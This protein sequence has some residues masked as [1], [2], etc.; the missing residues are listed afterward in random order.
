MTNIIISIIVVL[1]VAALFGWLAKRAWGSRKA[2]VKWAG[3]ILGG[4]LALV[5]LVVAVFAGLGI[6]KLFMK[7]PIA[8]PDVT[9]QGT[10]DQIA[11]GQHL[12]QVLCAGCHSLT[13]DLPL[14]GGKN[15]SADTGMPLG[16]IYAPNLTPAT[17]IKNWS[18]SDLFRVIRTGIDDQGRAT[19][20]TF[21]V[22]V[23]TLSDE[24]TLAVIAYLRQ[25]P[26]VVHATPEFKPTI[27]MALLAGAGMI[28]LNVPAT[29]TVVSGPPKAATV[30]YG[31]YVLTYMDCTSCHGEKLDGVVPPPAPAGPD[32]RN[33]F[34]HW[35]KDDFLNVVHAFAASAQPSDVMP[36]KD[37]SR[38][39]AVELE[40]LY[41]YLHKVTSK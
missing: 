30:E 20:M 38:M 25:S 3:L 15:L 4:L 11:R 21:F 2:F 18:D 19:A 17:D 23:H 13:G 27:L 9:V 26:A 24:D 22:G 5:L 28:P 14:S 32:I 40:A 31:K 10:P 33:Y 34:A 39:D 7:N 6:R 35:S 29:V 41:L 1:A 36:W 16:N 8:L 37:I 12:A